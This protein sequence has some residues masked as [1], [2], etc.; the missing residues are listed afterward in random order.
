MGGLIPNLEQN[1]K[2]LVEQ[3]HSWVTDDSLKNL[4]VDHYSLSWFERNPHQ[5]TTEFNTFTV[6]PPYSLARDCNYRQEEIVRRFLS[7]LSEFNR[8]VG[9]DDK[10][11]KRLINPETSFQTYFEIRIL[12]LVAKSGFS[13][14]PDHS[15]KKGRDVEALIKSNDIETLVEC[16]VLGLS[17][18]S[19]IHYEF[20]EQ[21]NQF[22]TDL[23]LDKSVNVCGEIKIKSDFG[24][25][26]WCL[27][28][29]ATNQA[30]SE[31]RGVKFENEEV[32]LLLFP[33][34]TQAHPNLQ[35]SKDY[36]ETERIKSTFKKTMKKL[37]GT[38]GCILFCCLP[39]DV[40][41][42][43]ALDNAKELL[44]S[45][46]FKKIHQVIFVDPKHTFEIEYLEI[47]NLIN[48][49]YTGP[50]LSWNKDKSAFNLSN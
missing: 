30:V 37:K 41:Q 49:S 34:P 4:L 14:K 17:D 32:K 2:Y 8:L 50:A 11:M 9:I 29:Q 12:S 5:F 7:S 25:E 33:G 44:K 39:G 31:K 48:P 45:G 19:K 23:N 28:S 18:T 22:V 1:H 36:P 42:S 35:T 16:K 26:T 10:R 15:T 43:S 24:K 27:V 40:G 3:I 21:Y 13:V 46:K 47:F 38:D 20:S 6:Q